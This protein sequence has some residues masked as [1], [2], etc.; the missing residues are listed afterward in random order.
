MSS[1]KL[2]SCLVALIIFS[3]FLT[4]C[5]ASSPTSSPAIIKN[6]TCDM[7]VTCGDREYACSLKRENDISLISVKEPTELDGLQLEYS[8]GVYS[9]SFKGLKMSIDD[10]E[11]QLTKH[12]ADGLMKIMDKT[13]SLEEISAVDEGGVLLYEGE[14]TYGGFELRFDEEGKLL[15]AR[16]PSIDTE[17]AFENFKEIE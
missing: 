13:F 2:S 12:F 1:Y 16:I 15:S 17:I 5:A 7:F 11:A 6:F 3:F 8:S 9:V 14:T 4:G 10:S